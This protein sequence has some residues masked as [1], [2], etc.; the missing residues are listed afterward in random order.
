MSQ[1]N[2]IVDNDWDQLLEET[3]NLDEA[4]LEET[5]VEESTE[6]TSTDQVSTETHVA[7][8]TDNPVNE[9]ASTKDRP[10]VPDAETARLRA[11]NARLTREAEQR[12]RE[13]QEA[14]L[15][16]AAAQYAQQRINHYAAQGYDDQ[17]ARQI[18]VLEAKEQLAAYRAQQAELSSARTQLHY[19]YNVPLQ[20]LQGFSDTAAMR[21]YAEQYSNTTG[22]QASKVASLEKELA[23]LKTEIRQSRV[24]AQNFNRTGNGSA[25]T[26]QA[27]WDS[28]GRGEREYTP[29]VQRAEKALGLR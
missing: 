26:A 7:E 21:H 13:A 3:V 17:T 25:S 2:P 14:E 19:E 9:E 29:E 11:E 16:N 15:Q 12:G 28:Y 20:Q 1:Q 8:E 22:P 6:E 27:I 5:E 18:G 23:A 24:P 10:V 4:A